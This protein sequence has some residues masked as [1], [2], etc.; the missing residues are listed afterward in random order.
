M[1]ADGHPH[2]DRP[3]RPEAA[4]PDGQERR[5]DAGCERSRTLRG[6]GRSRG[7]G[8]APGLHVTACPFEP[9]LMTGRGLVGVWGVW[10]A[11]PV[12]G[13]VVTWMGAGESGGLDVMR[14]GRP[15]LPPRART[16]RSTD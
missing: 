1:A 12:C 10:G 5:P 11:V 13:S 3:D 15:W 2:P 8:R 14:Q 9:P 4:A 16:G 6:A 7:G